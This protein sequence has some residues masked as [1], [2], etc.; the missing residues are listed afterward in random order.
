MGI[1]F[2]QIPSIRTPG[3]FSEFSADRAT[4]NLGLARQ[5]LIIGQ[6]LSTGT[7]AEGVVIE[8]SSLDLA[9]DAAGVGSHFADMVSK[10]LENDTSVRLRGILLDDNA[11]GVA[12]VKTIT[13]TGISHDKRC[14]DHSK[15]QG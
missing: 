3:V 2:S 11:G 10:L 1:S 12:N 9:K 4:S 13:V 6:R 15:A 8:V 14:H 5:R 7:V